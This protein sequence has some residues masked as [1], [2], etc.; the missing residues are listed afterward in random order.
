VTRSSV[1]LTPT[2]SAL[3]RS[4]KPRKVP[5]WFTLDER[6]FTT[7]VD[8]VR[9]ELRNQGAPLS[10]FVPGRV[11]R[12]LMTDADHTLIKTSSPIFVLT[13]DKNLLR[14]RN[15]KIVMLGLKS[16]D[17]KREFAALVAKYPPE[18]SRHFTLDFTEYGSIQSVLEAREIESTLRE[19]R[20][21]ELSGDDKR[22]FV[23]TARSNDTAIGAL[24]EYLLDR[25]VSA[26]GIFAVNNT[27]QMDA[28]GLATPKLNTAQRKAV[29]MAALIQVYSSLARPLEELKFLD[30]TDENLI[31]AMQLLPSLFPRT[32]FEFADVVHEGR[33]HYEQRLVAQGRGRLTG[34]T[35][36]ALTD[37]EIASYR[38]KDL[39]LNHSPAHQAGLVDS[40]SAARSKTPG[41]ISLD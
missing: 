36:R 28:L 17:Y 11:S 20:L 8:R 39:P 10:S 34:P 26:D 15:G 14:D 22:V 24:E 1:S 12:L 33:G 37:D 23:I 5:E 38:S 27:K 18:Q 31:A 6:A 16:A 40:F 25:R 35:G 29:V 30:D 32:R 3:V 7:L 9:N 41:P 19:M 21:S 13:E 4:P 2:Q